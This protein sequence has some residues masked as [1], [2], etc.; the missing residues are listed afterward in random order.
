MPEGAART[1]LSPDQAGPLKGGLK[2]LANP[3]LVF[4][5]LPWLMILL[6]IGTI[7]QKDMG[8]YEATRT[9]FSSFVFWFG[10]LPLPGGIPTLG[11]VFAGLLAKFLLYSPW[12][13]HQAGIILTHFGVLLLIFGGLVTALTQKE[14]FMVIKEGSSLGSVSDY[15]HRILTVLKDDEPYGT[16]PF[17][18]LKVKEKAEGVA[19]PFTLTPV[20]LCDNCKPAPVPS[21]QE[22][23]HGL[24]AKIDLAKAKPE[25]EN[26]ANL[27]GALFKVEGVDAAQDGLYLSMEEIPHQPSVTVDGHSYSFF[28][29]RAQT[30]LPFSLT[31]DDFQKE[32][33]P[34]TQMA[35]AY[36]SNVTVQD[37]DVAWPAL[38]SMNNP[39]RY[40][41]YTFYQSSFGEGPD[42]ERSVLSVVENKGRLFPYIASAIIFAGL[43]LHILIR[44]RS[45]EAA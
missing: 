11:V 12:R 14:G 22:T 1:P 15:H 8:I 18:I 29:T 25:K 16:I 41:G 21:S 39:L 35:K 36:S 26:E 44:L 5:T 42:G 20:F 30:A 33:Y 4:Y 24:A 13:K 17:P 3:A 6:L 37:G 43:L 19:L 45:R 38:I 7:A 9:Y 32:L 28:L 40:K 2:A 31:L 23:R 27:S 34:G 10:P